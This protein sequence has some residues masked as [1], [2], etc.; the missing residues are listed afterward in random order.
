MRKKIPIAVLLTDSH[1]H[2][3]NISQVEDIWEQAIALCRKLKVNRILHGGDMV[4]ARQAQPL[5]VLESMLRT[6]ARLLEEGLELDAIEGNHDRSNLEA[7][8]GYP[9]V[10]ATDN[11]RIHPAST[12]LD[13]DDVIIHMLSYFPENG[14]YCERLENLNKSVKK[15]K[16]N[17]LVTHVGVNGGLSHESASSNK[18]VPTSI[19]SKF[20]TVLIGHYHNQCQIDGT[21]IYYVGS[22]HQSNF[23]EDSNKGFTILYSDGSHEFVKS[24][25][26]EFRT[27]QIDADEIDT[28]FLKKLKKDIDSSGDKVRVVIVG[29]DSKLKTVDKKAFVEAGVS[30][31]KLRSDNAEFED[32]AAPTVTEYV[33]FTKKEIVQEYKKFSVANE[34]DS[35]LGLEYLQEIKG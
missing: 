34:F 5:S 14:S 6:R 11:F 3:D 4:T 10:F 24:K 32:K 26:Q 22:T 20:D 30:K 1:L 2:K 16:F 12:T 13:F 7:E 18:E 8:F 19:F 21:E 28:K 15:K 31:I 9:S 23:G 29:D 17:I 33:S 27:M 25:F 35:E